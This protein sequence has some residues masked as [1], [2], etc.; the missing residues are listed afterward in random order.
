MDI[1]SAECTWNT[2][3]L[4]TDRT[5]SGSRSDSAGSASG[6]AW[7]RSRHRAAS[8]ARSACPTRARA[9]LRAFGARELGA[10]LA[11]LA[12]PDRADVVVVTGR[13]RRRRPFLPGHRS[14]RKQQQTAIRDGAGGIR[15]R[16]R[17]RRPVCPAAAA[18]PAGG[19]RPTAPFGST[20][21]RRSTARYTRSID[22][23]RQLR[24]LPEIHAAP[25]IGR[26]DARRAPLALAR[27]GSGRHD[28]RV[29]SRGASRSAKT[30]RSPGGRCQ[31]PA[32]RTAGPFV[33]PPHLARAEPKFA[34]SSS[35]A[36]PPARSAAASPG[37]SGR[38]PI[39]RSTKICAASSSSWRPGKS[40]CRRDPSLLARGTARRP[41]RTNPIARGGALM[42]AN[43]WYGTKTVARRGRARS[44]DPQRTRRDRQA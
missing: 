36:R 1:T 40:R 13:R 12:E 26:G 44:E 39:S 29:G 28:G 25:R 4:P 5:P 11:I 33:S 17:A 38:N 10:G 18:N 22:F 14:Q 32:S 15:R 23:W 42:K 34:S 3:T 21:W 43:C 16:D 24:E 20:G 9:V 30:S 35:T 7:S 19:R 2:I 8:L 37:C 27:Q 41:T 6:S 31:A